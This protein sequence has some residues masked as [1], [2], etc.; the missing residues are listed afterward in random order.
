[1]HGMPIPGVA[2]GG[3]GDRLG[4][5][6]PRRLANPKVGVAEAKSPRTNVV[7]TARNCHR[8][9]EKA[10]RKRLQP[11]QV[12]RPRADY[13]PGRGRLATGSGG[14]AAAPREARREHVEHWSR[15]GSSR[16]A[17]PG[18]RSR[19]P[20]A[21]PWQRKESRRGRRRPRQRGG[22]RGGRPP[23]RQQ[24]RTEGA[25]RAWVRAEQSQGHLMAGSITSGIGADRRTIEHTG[26]GTSGPPRLGPLPRAAKPAGTPRG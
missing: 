6:D 10:R 22:A 3:R 1:V 13:G 11:Q 24:K 8:G 4:K 2:L 23:R 7:R 14:S 12:G 21:G 15:P 17:L 25:I 16:R 18:S 5:Q 9:N 19:H 20:G 26:Q